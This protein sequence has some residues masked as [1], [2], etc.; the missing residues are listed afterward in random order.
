MP[1]KRWASPIRDDREQA[2]TI[3]LER[4]A[5]A[6]ERLV[7]AADSIA[8]A[9][10]LRSLFG[11]IAPQPQASADT[12]LDLSIAGY[13]STRAYNCLRNAGI[14]TFRQLTEITEAEL[15]CIPGIWRFVSREIKNVLKEEGLTLKNQRPTNG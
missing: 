5:D 13:L 3:N 2:D 7:I 4:I 8:T 6:L 9:L 10:G 12:K 1:R 15:L 14:Q 11:P